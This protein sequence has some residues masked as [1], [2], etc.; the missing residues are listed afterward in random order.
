MGPR[1]AVWFSPWAAASPEGLMGTICFQTPPSLPVSSSPAV[2]QGP[3]PLSATGCPP[4]L[5]EGCALHGACSIRVRSPLLPPRRPAL[6]LASWLSVPL[7]HARRVGLPQTF[8]VCHTCR[9]APRQTP[10]RLTVTSD[11]AARN[12]GLHLRERSIHHL[13]QRNN[14]N[15]IAQAKFLLFI[16]VNFILV[17]YA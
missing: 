15:I 14:G 16:L 7:P 17:T 6:A 11:L 12:P 5:P 8:R 1:C 13:P 10:G 3:R 4:P 2:D 9:L